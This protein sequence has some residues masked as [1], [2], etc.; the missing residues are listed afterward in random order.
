MV[1]LLNNRN[2]C[3]AIMTHVLT[4]TNY[5]VGRSQ[6]QPLIIIQT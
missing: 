2:H 5:I 3:I 6:W 4:D 1:Y